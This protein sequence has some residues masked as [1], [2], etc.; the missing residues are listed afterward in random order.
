M[1]WKTEGHVHE[2]H[3][4]KYITLLH[5]SDP[6]TF[7]IGNGTELFALCK[8]VLQYNSFVL[9][10]NYICSQCE[11]LFKSD[12]QMYAW[13]YV[14]SNIKNKISKILKKNGQ[15]KCKTEYNVHPCHGQVI[16]TTQFNNYNP[17]LIGIS[18][19]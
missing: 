12:K 3:V 9:K 8:E 19:W 1:V 6:E 10:H 2:V 11:R 7:T 5:A 16:M 14:N 17:P 15:T 4:I 13:W 18:N